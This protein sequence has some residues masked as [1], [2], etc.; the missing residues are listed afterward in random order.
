MDRQAIDTTHGGQ[1]GEMMARLS[2][3]LRTPLNA[4]IG[5]SEIMQREMLGPLGGERYHGYATHIR[6][7]GVSLLAAV[8]VALSITQKLAAGELV[9]VA[10]ERA[11]RAGLGAAMGAG[12]GGPRSEGLV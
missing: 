5:F 2:H 4:I 12:L 10:P 3:D 1:V 6:D 9:L 11:S 8:E 7:S